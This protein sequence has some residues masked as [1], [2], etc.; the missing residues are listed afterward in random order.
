VG[1]LGEIMA[2]HAAEA[3]TAPEHRPGQRT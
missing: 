3:P 2:A 1:T